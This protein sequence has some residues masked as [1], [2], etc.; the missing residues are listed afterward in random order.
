MTVGLFIH[1]MGG[2]YPEKCGTT[3]LFLK[4]LIQ[5]QSLLLGIL[6]ILTIYPKT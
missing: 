1:Q 4:T 2:F 5:W 6:E 3:W